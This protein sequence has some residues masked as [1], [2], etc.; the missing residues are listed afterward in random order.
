MEVMLLIFKDNVLFM[1]DEDI[2]GIYC[3]VYLRVL[4]KFIKLIVYF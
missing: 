1:I 2:Y 3:K 4:V